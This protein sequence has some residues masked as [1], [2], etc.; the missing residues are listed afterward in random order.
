MSAALQGVKRGAKHLLYRSGA[1]SLV[2]RSRDHVRVLMYHGVSSRSLAPE[3]FEQ[4]VRYLAKHFDFYWASEIPDLL[5]RVPRLSRPAIVLTFDDGLRNNVVNVVP[6]LERYRAKATFY[7]VSDLLDGESM[8]W[9]HEILCRL[10]LLDP[11]GLREL[12]LDFSSAPNAKWRL[13]QRF[14]EG[15]KDR[16]DSDR[17]ALLQRLRDRD[18]A[19]AYT[20]WMLEEYRIMSGDELKALPPLVEIGSHTRTH[21]I[22]DTVSDEIAQREIVGS[23]ERL[24]T[25]LGRK[26]RTFCYP[27][28]RFSEQA[29]E[30]A[31]RAYDLAVTVEQGYVR[32]GDPLHRLKRVLPGDS[33][34]E[35]MLYLYRP[36]RIHAA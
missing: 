25:I 15:L 24:E 10:A 4:Q 35:L 7:V 8:I 19:P 23:R 36:P 33:M 22:L 21:P 28:G 17:Q 30:I 1:L 13:L 14:V 16:P 26:V 18:A 6:V 27:N 34:Q 32:K 20:D 31:K 3:V 5:A 9:N 11:A 29:T 12:S 2:A